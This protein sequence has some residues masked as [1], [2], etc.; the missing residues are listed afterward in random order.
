MLLL[1]VPE[2]EINTPMENRTEGNF[3]REIYVQLKKRYEQYLDRPHL[4][5][6]SI[7]S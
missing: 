6:W 2:M 1:R 7:D 5:I 4:I 3:I